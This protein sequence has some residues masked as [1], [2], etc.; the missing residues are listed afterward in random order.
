LGWIYPA[1]LTGAV[2]TGAGIAMATEGHDWR[3]IAIPSI[4]VGV[5]DI[6][7]AVGAY[8]AKPAIVPA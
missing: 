1:Y 6:G 8:R 2:M 4:V 7:I 5:L 3:A